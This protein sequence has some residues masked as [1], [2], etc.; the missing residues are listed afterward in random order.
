METEIP[1][2]VKLSSRGQLV[3]PE[4]IREKLH[5]KTGSMLEIL[6]ADNMVVIKKIELPIKE[7]DLKT[8]KRLKKAWVDFETGKGKRYSEKEYRK[9]LEHGRI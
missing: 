2:F 7:R 5:L 6:K 1:E 4:N 3:I 8:L 9:R